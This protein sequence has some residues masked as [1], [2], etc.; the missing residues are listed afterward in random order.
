MK[1]T[2][3]SGFFR[4]E[5]SLTLLF[6]TPAVPGSICRQRMTQNTDIQE[7]RLP[8]TEGFAGSIRPPGS[9]SIA[10]RAL[11]LAALAQGKTLLRNIPDAD[12]V[13]ILKKT[14]PLLGV[15]VQTVKLEK[16]RERLEITGCGGPFPVQSA[17][18][19]LENAGTAIRPMLPILS[20]GSGN[21]TIDGNEQMR[22]RPIR[23]L[24][25]S[26]QSLG[27][28]VVCETGCPPLQLRAKGLAGGRVSISG[29]TSSQF[30]TALLLAAPLADSDM[31]IISR[32]DP[33][34]KPY[35]DM[36]IRMMGDFGVEVKRDGYR[37]FF[38][39]RGKYTSPGEYVIES[40]AT[41][42]TYFLAAGALPGSGPV[43][44]KGIGKNS[45]Q[46]DVRFTEIL[47]R[48]GARVSKDSES[49]GSESPPG[50]AKLRSIDVDMNDMPDA[51]MTLAVLAL[52]AEGKT[53]IRNIG[54]LR[55]K[56]SERIHG[57]WS[58]LSKL[59]AQVREEEDALYI[60]PAGELKDCSI[61]TYRDHRMAMAFALA[62]RGTS[63]G[64]LDPGC[65]SKTYPHF[66]EDF[67]SLRR[68]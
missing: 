64:I 31:E 42:A 39:R 57:L 26:L 2:K 49:L 65:V 18:L 55:V 43:I 17:N 30:L 38:V 25:E 36:T 35:I 6:L 10:N 11:F 16:G 29:K 46:G 67:L 34:S 33:V 32:D 61:E 60:Q 8:R 28:D 52:F 44:V 62:S 22:K 3:Y 5:R 68:K 56:E 47:E 40:D 54:N 48:M 41:A 59:G 4:V 13:Q 15:G 1:R 14:L 7:L 45:I 37:S 19:Y 23:D 12:D 9:K 63:L 58:E 21:F 66:F 51:A 53:S 50:N 27:V 24:V 20:A